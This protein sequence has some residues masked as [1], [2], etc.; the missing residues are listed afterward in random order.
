[1]PQNDDATSQERSGL[2]FLQF[3][4]KGIRV[5]FAG[6]HAE[7]GLGGLLR[8]AGTGGGLHASVGTPWGAH[9]GAGLGGQVS[10]EEGTV[11]GG[12]YARAGLGNGRPEAA[13]GL[14]GRLDG[15]GRS[16]NP[17][18]GGMYAGATPGGGLG[19]G[20]FLGGG[21]GKNG[22]IPFAA[23]SDVSYTGFGDSPQ[24]AGATTTEKTD[25][26][27][28]AS[29]EAKAT[30]GRTNIQII[31]SRSRKEKE[32]VA[33][34]AAALPA[35]AAAADIKAEPK[36]NEV[37]RAVKYAAIVPPVAQLDVVGS[38]SAGAVVPAVTATK[39][40]EKNVLVPAVPIP[41]APLIVPVA[42]QVNANA[43]AS[44]DNNT[45]P[46]SR[47]VY[48]RWY[49]RKRFWNVP[50]KTVYVAPIAT[51]IQS[52]SNVSGDLAVANTVA[53]GG[54]AVVAGKSYSGSLFDDIFNIPISTLAAVNQL[55]NNVG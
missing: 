42:T 39:T 4:D 12:L 13:A 41:A 45:V 20:V 21:V 10:G 44:V 54:V 25:A 36:N 11:G 22:D 28:S 48:P 43:A 26:A 16:V 27:A 1:M 17:I 51:E 14:G 50:R 33:V 18:A 9:A 5:N 19:T 3:T 7:A 31:P 55:L 46:V 6:Y 30:R 53:D 32:K 23:P 49:F 24:A 52:A 40:V 8:G 47:I 29:S 38:I 37:R 2:P 35:N 15:S 34:E